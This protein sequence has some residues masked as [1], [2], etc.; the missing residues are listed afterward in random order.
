MT[1]LSSSDAAIRLN[2]TEQG[3]YDKVKKGNLAALSIAGTKNS[4]YYFP[5]PL[6]KYDL[7]KGSNSKCQVYVCTNIK[8][9]VGKTTVSTNLAHALSILGK[10]V[11]LVDMDPQ[12]DGTRSFLDGR[13]EN[14]ITALFNKMKDKHNPSYDEIKA[15]MTRVEKK[16]GSFDILPSSLSLARTID[17]LRSISN[18]SVTRLDYILSQVK[19]DYDYIV[20]DTPPNT[21]ATMQMSLYAADSVLIVAQPEEF[22]VEGTEALLGEID[23]VRSDIQFIKESHGVS[24]SSEDTLR[25]GALIVNQVKNLVIHKD[26]ITNLTKI[27]DAASIATMYLVPDDSKVKECQAL[28]LSVFEYKDEIDSGFKAGG[29]ILQL[30]FDI[31]NGEL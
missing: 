21:S 7:K 13:P 27:K 11:L 15:T 31:T 8:G 10:K 17:D 12:G 14:T 23:S 6:L 25:V 1:L 5:E 30:A 29:Q 2:I 19:K 26:Y 9:G 18:L 22:S 20:L 16:Q 4:K 24:I 3:L 28:K